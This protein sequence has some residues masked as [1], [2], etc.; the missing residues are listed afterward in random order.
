MVFVSQ[1][2]LLFQ[3]CPACK[4]DNI[5]VEMS[6][7]ETMV[8]MYLDCGNST[9]I[10]K[11]SV[12]YSQPY[13]E[14]T[15]IPA[16]NVL[17]SMAILVAGGSAS[18]VLKVFSHMGMACISLATSFKHQ[19]VYANII[20]GCNRLL[21]LYIYII[22]NY[23]KL[24]YF[25][26][27]KLLP[28]ISLHWKKYQSQIIEKLKISERPLSMA[29]DGRHDSTGHSAN[30]CAYTTFCCTSPRTIHFSLVQVRKL[31]IFEYYSIMNLSNV[32]LF[33]YN[34]EMNL[35]AV[36]GWNTWHS[37]IASTTSMNLG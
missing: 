7:C 31:I 9:C 33:S 11:Q 30:Y 26:Q 23:V 2:M 13:T 8:V 3:F 29:G 4:S 37:N 32:Y 1:L 10:Q 28:A 17:L 34:R 25:F 16:G 36:R 22:L 27:E 14:E 20:L 5:L 18:K 19:R 35:R 24:M 6:Q 15:K 21:H 12:W